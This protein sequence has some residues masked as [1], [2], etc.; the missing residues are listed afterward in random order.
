[1]APLALGRAQSEGAALGRT[2]QSLSPERP[3][4]KAPPRELCHLGPAHWHLNERPSSQC[5]SALSPPWSGWVGGGAP[6]K[7]LWVSNSHSPYL[8]T[9]ETFNK[10]LRRR[11]LWG[12]GQIRR[13]DLQRIGERDSNHLETPKIQE[14]AWGRWGEILVF[15]MLSSGSRCGP[16]VVIKG[17]EPPSSPVQNSPQLRQERTR[18]AGGR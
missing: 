1:M 10:H 6:D 15:S 14:Q 13:L 5:E 2:P 9:P 7:D 4:G 17:E 16:P 18:V 11:R 8:Y 3:R 12:R